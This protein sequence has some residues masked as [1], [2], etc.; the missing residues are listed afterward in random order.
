MPDTEQIW[1]DYQAKLSGFINANV[2]DKAAADDI[3][4]EVFLKIHSKIETINDD[5]KIQSWIFQI[6]K[7]TIVDSYRKQRFTEALPD[8]LTSEEANDS[9]EIRKE[10]A[11][12]IVPMID[13]LSETYREAL[14]MSE[15]QGLS[16]KEIAEELGLSLS[17]A[18]SRVQ[19]G[20]GMVKDML[21]QCCHFE[22][23]RTGRLIDYSD[24]VECCSTC[25][26]EC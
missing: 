19:R 15:V 7:N 3:L 9:D 8:C 2:K 10:V 21:L 20:R 16:Q 1:M 4:Q 22:F 14:I 17:G 26:K 18:K 23:D 24:R 25:S 11:G 13:R 12:W 6:A 5:D